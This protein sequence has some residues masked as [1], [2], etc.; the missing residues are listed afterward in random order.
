M[1]KAITNALN[2]NI[3]PLEKKTYDIVYTDGCGDLDNDTEFAYTLLEARNQF[4]QHMAG[5]G[6]YKLDSV[7]LR[8]G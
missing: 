5:T 4:I 2:K 7:T 6:P 8:E 3:L 1:N